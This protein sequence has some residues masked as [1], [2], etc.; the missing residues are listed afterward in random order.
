MTT[1]ELMAVAVLKGDT[2]AARALADHLM[3][4]FATGQ[5]LPPVRTFDVRAGFRLKAIAIPPESLSAVPTAGARAVAAS[6]SNWLDAR[7]PATAVLPPGWRVDLYELPDRGVSPD[8]VAARV[9]NFECDLDGHGFGSIRI[10]G[11]RVP[12]VVAFT[13]TVDVDNGPR[14]TLEQSIRDDRPRGPSPE[15][16]ITVPEQE[17]VHEAARGAAD[18]DET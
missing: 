15:L 8:G 1:A 3:G 9:G 17:A 18:R 11:V 2:T 7:S 5:E 16:V 6:V 13:L 10:G 14:L 4:E 12:D